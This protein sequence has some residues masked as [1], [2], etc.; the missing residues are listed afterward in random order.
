MLWVIL[1]IVTF[2]LLSRIDIKKKY[3]ES[4]LKKEIKKWN[5]EEVILFYNQLVED[6]EQT[7][8][9]YEK[10]KK[11]IHKDSKEPRRKR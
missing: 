8:K 10:F 6:F 2:I 11:T 9:D 5:K 1:L 4:K 3:Y 7:K